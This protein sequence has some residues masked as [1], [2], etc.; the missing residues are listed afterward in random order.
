MQPWAVFTSSVAASMWIASGGCG[1]WLWSES[2]VS[3]DRTRGGGDDVADQEQHDGRHRD[4]EIDQGA[5]DDD[6]RA[7]QSGCECRR[8]QVLIFP[9]REYFSVKARRLAARPREKVRARG[10][11]FTGMEPAVPVTRVMEERASGPGGCWK[12]HSIPLTAKGQEA[13]IAHSA[14]GHELEATKWARVAA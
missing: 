8:Q 14:R 7:D 6:E 9:G 5:V 2:F 11:C 13:R 12:V 1:S 4:Q 3:V 10:E